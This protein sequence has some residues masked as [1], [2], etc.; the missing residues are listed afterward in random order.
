[1]NRSSDK[2]SLPD[3]TPLGVLQR[4]LNTRP[5]STAF[6]FR[7][8]TW[9]YQRL[10]TVAKRL[11]QGLV[12]H[13]I[14]AG[15]RIALHMKN[16]PEMLVAYFACFELGAIAA[17]LRT[18]F[19][20]AELGPLLQRLKPALYIGEIGL[21]ENVARIDV[22]ILA[23]E[24]RFVVG[25]EEAGDLQPWSRLF[26]GSA[27]APGEAAPAPHAPALLINTSGTT[28]QP[29][30]V[31]H[32]PAT[33][34]EGAV[35]A[36]DVW[37]VTSEDTVPHYFALAHASGVII[38]LCLIQAGAAF[39]MFESFDADATLD[40]IERNGCAL[41]MGF[42]A[43][44]AALL[45]R[46]RAKPRNL[47][48]LRLCLVGGDACPLDL[49]EQASKALGAP[50]YN[51]WAATEVPTGALSY[52]PKSGRVARVLDEARI[53]LVDNDGNDVPRGEVGE[54]LVT[55]PTVFAGYWDDP[56]ATADSLRD[57][58]YHTGDLMRRGD[59]D[60]IWFVARKKDL[61]IRSGTN[62]SPVE[63]EQAMVASCPGIELAAA[64]GIPDKVL[65]QR[66]FGFVKLAAG[67][68]NTIVPDLLRETAKRIADYKMPEDLA[69]LP[70]M[71]WTVL[72]KLDRNVLTAMA[73]ERW[74]RVDSA[75]L[76]P[77]PS[78]ERSR[79]LMRN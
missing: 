31:I 45:E 55:G 70:E 79:D 61:I 68:S 10:A 44:Y 63:I 71:P 60:D 43:Q 28:G 57:G 49:Q 53:R 67:A 13:G 23:A 59:G 18:A 73:V 36:V 54:L 29:K 41:T 62:I 9:S 78:A 48:S 52:V 42:P 66:I 22:S 46:Q 30:F 8:D 6:V 3:K 27:D 26:E 37:G 19:K 25:A 24:K 76:Q 2:T 14:K 74:T 35:A 65:G 38:S 16:R 56:K 17:P 69:V 11:A 12:A 72:G 64:V 20:A 40:V 15:D 7:D 47:G 51:I 33:L 39:V 1:M 4:Q 50:L 34:Y 21:Y 75:A 77:Q 58:W 32:T 5:S